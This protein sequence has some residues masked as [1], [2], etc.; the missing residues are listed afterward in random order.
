MYAKKRSG[1]LSG[2][3]KASAKSPPSYPRDKSPEELLSDG[4]L[5][6]AF[7]IP[8]RPTTKKTHQ[9]IAMVRGRPLIIQSS[10]YTKYE[11][12]CRP[13]CE[14]AW[15]F[16]GKKPMDYGIAIK[17]RVYLND[18]QIGDH[19][20]YMQSIGDILEKHGVIADDMF[21]HWDQDPGVHWFGGKEPENPRVE[22][23]IRRFRHPYEEFRQHKEDE[24]LRK[25]ANREKRAGTST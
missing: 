20:G 11:K 24:E 15:K 12:E 8:G 25:Q 9:Q 7:T 23:E 19:V 4:E 21:I 14:A 16:M 2:K 6:C 3:K 1:A 18:W 5:L 10:T 13:H 17:L 22:I